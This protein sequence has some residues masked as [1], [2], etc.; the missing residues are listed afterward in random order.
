MGGPI[1]NLEIVMA[2]ANVEGAVCVGRYLH[3]PK[4]NW[5]FNTDRKHGG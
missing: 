1:I 2:T 3:S 4:R 5:I